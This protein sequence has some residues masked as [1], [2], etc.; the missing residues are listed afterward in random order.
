M[1]IPP[2][3]LIRRGNDRAT[4]YL[5]SETEISAIITAAGTL[6]PRFRA[7]AYQALISLLAVSGIRV[8]EA[9]APDS[10]DLDADDGVLVVP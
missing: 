3:G 1:R 4:R 6:R 8:G 9:L 7:A 2:A 10:N 5:Y